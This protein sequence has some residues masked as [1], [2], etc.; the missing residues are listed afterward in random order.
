MSRFHPAQIVNSNGVEPT[1]RT[2]DGDG[3][4]LVAG[5]KY[6]V[7]ND[8]KTWLHV[9]NG[10]SDAVFTLVTSIPRDGVDYADKT[11]TVPANEE[12]AIFPR[13]HNLY[14]DPFTFS[15]SDVTDV[16]IAVLKL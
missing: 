2:T 9:K 13:D 3:N 12:R 15:I 10:A 5:H 14:G 6:T 1:Y 7:A 4:D 11:V 16:S 8:G